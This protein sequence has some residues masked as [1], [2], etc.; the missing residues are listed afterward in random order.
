MA[1]ANRHYLPG[2]VRHLKRNS[3][4][5]SLEF[6]GQDHI[7]RST[8]ARLN[9]SNYVYD[10]NHNLTQTTNALSHTTTNTYDSLFRMTGTSDPLSH[11]SSFTYDTHHHLTGT[12]S[13]VG[14]TTAATY[15]STGLRQTATDGRGIV[16]SFTY[17]SYGSP[18]TSITGSHPAITYSYDSIGRMTGLTDQ[19]GSSTAFTYDTRGLLLSVTDPLG[20]AASFTYD[21]AGQLANKTDRLNQTMQYGYTPTGKVQSITYPDSSVTSFTYNNLDRLIQVRDSVG[22]TGYAYDAA[23]R[24]SSMTTPYELSVAYAYD[25]AGNIN[26]VTYPGNRKVIYTYDALNRLSTVRI[27]WLNLEADYTYDQ[28]GRLTGLTNFNGTQTTYTYDNANRLITMEN[29]TGGGSISSYGFTLDG[30]ASRTSATL[31][32]PYQTT[33]TAE[34]VAYTYNDKKNRLL[35]AGASSFAYDNEGQLNSGYGSTYAFDYEHRLTAIGTDAQ[36]SYDYKGN[37]LQAIRNGTITRYINDPAGNLLAE[38]D[39]GNNITK[40]YIQGLSLLAMVMSTDQVYNYHYNPIGSTIAVTDLGQNV[41]NAY[42]Y[43]SF[44]NILNQAENIPQPFKYVGQLGVM[45]ETN[46]FYYMRA[47][48][49]DPQVGRFISE[50]PSGFDGGDV[51]LYAYVGGN[52]VN[53]SDPSG[54]TWNSNF[55]F[56][57]DFGT[58]SGSNN[59]VYNAG[60][61]ETQEISASPGANALRDAF[62]RGGGATIPRF[63]Y[64][65]DQAAKDTVLNPSYWSS[66]ALQVGGFDGAS[67]VNNGNGTVTFTIPNEAGTRSFFYHAVDDRT[68]TTGPMRTIK[69]IFTWT[70]PI[71]GRCGRR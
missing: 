19:A 53:R 47:R 51:N 13:A 4:K 23:G 61:T 24:L 28:A 57:L 65:S 50:D 3:R 46:G 49:Y 64:A 42:A 54:L 21:N 40:Y 60:T 26:Q 18:H 36:Y 32:E 63:T 17:D 1:R 69:Q 39:G 5:S 22:M 12:Q 7:V 58:G 66:T 37:R 10:G 67:A 14:N 27:D 45:A 56:L 29:R 31:S 55:R 25:E 16:S 8:D 15:F 59:R 2:Y 35:T 20:R 68:G 62:Y 41:V 11:N 30:N 9:A 6:D 44:G 48:Y 43:D 34:N 70:E 71:E 38:T 33:P 52:A